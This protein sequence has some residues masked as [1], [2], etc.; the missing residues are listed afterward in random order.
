MLNYL[1]LQ[2]ENDEPKLT[3]L[4]KD[5]NFHKAEEVRLLDE[6][7]ALRKEEA[8]MIKAIEEQELISKEIAVEEERYRKEYIRHQ[9]EFLSLEDE[10]RR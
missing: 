10:G 4:E 9:K 8:E 5:L 2:N 6:L 7:E 1:R 3:E